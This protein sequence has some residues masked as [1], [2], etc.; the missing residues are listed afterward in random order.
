MC[1]DGTENFNLDGVISHHA[2]RV[3]VPLV[4]ERFILRVYEYIIFK[5]LIQFKIQI[6]ERFIYKRIINDYTILITFFSFF[7]TL[8]IA[9]NLNK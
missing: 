3:L 7:Y 6:D 9:L 5:E 2:V 4:F 8:N 1:Q